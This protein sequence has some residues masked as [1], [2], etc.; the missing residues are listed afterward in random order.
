LINKK[1]TDIENDIIPIKKNNL[2][3]KSILIV[4]HLVTRGY[5]DRYELKMW[6]EEI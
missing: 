5:G 1:K 3:N 4:S 2:N 6:L